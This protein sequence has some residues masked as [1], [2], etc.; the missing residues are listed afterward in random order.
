MSVS[1]YISYSYIPLVHSETEE[2]EHAECCVK[3]LAQVAIKFS[4]LGWLSS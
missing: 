4:E 1:A 3:Y 2:Q